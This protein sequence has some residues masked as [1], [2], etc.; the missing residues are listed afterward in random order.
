MPAVEQTLTDAIRSAE[1]LGFRSLTYRKR[2]NAR[3]ACYLKLIGSWFLADVAV[4]IYPWFLWNGVY[5][6]NPRFRAIDK[7]FLGLLRRSK[8]QVRTILFVIDLPIE[9]AIVTGDGRNCDTESYEIESRILRC[10]DILCVYNAAMR[11]II[12]SRYDLGLEKFVEFEYFD[13]GIQP[14]SQHETSVCKRGWKVFY[15][16]YWDKYYTGDWVSRL[17]PAD[18][19]AYHFVGSNWDWLSG[20]KRADFSWHSH[21]TQQELCDYLYSNADFGIIAYAERLSSYLDYACPSKF[22]AYV[23]AGVP[24]LVSANCK[25]VASLVEKYS[26]GLSFDSVEQIPDILDH[27]SD[28]D[29]ARLRERC[30]ML[31]KKLT[32]GYFFKRALGESLRKLHVE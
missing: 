24:I 30:Q 12:R 14:H 20:E 10:F 5:N 25:Y 11:E 28:T 31:A 2:L 15:T 4:A 21:M 16:G 3:P 32:Q 13:Y 17:K 27:L 26:V 19:V 7:A 29:Y 22:G 6:F 1:N 23:T 18:N 8:R 9:Q